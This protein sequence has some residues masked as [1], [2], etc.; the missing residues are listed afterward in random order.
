MCEWCWLLHLHISSVLVEKK[1][2]MCQTNIWFLLFWRKQ[3]RMQI[4]GQMLYIW[5]QRA[6][7]PN[8]QCTMYTLSKPGIKKNLNSNKNCSNVYVCMIQ[9][10][11]IIIEF[12][13]RLFWL[14]THNQWK[15]GIIQHC[16]LQQNQLVYLSISPK[17]LKI[18]TIDWNNQKRHRPSMTLAYDPTLRSQFI[19]RAS[20]K[21]AQNNQLGHLM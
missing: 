11:Y 6:T 15:L 20:S 12:V 10:T 17:R 16:V 18:G 19:A 2:L 14:H 21:L 8:L 13:I 7:L 1:Y 4:D 3:I 5:E 9:C